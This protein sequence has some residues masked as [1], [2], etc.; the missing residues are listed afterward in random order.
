MNANRDLVTEYISS[1]KEFL[2]S[3]INLW[4]IAWEAFPLFHSQFADHLSK[5]LFLL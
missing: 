1:N 4:G 5:I 2:P 3:M